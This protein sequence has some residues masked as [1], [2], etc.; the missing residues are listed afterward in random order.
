MATTR[1]Q[2]EHLE[3]QAHVGVPLHERRRRQRLILDIDCDLGQHPI[4]RDEIRAT[5]NYALLYES[6]HALIATS[7]FAL[8]ETLAEAV[9]HLCLRDRRV[10]EVTV[11]VRKPKKLPN[12][13]SVGVTRSF[14][15]SEVP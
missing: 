3:V 2:L 7:A 15:Q 6:I 10:I 1:I 12:C 9:A 5:L 11:R 8:I 4:P 14:H 13:L